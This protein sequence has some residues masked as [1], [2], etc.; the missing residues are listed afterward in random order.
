[1]HLCIEKLVLG[2]LQ[3]NVYILG[4]EDS[5]DAVII[6]PTFEPERQLEEISRRK[7]VLR[8]IWLTHGHYDHTTGALHISTAFD[9]SLPIAM[10]PESFTWAESQKN[11]IKFGL[12][13]D[14]V[15][16]LTTPLFQGKLLSLH[17]NGGEIVA[18]VREVPG[19]NP[20]SV[21]FYC[22]TINTAITGD[23]I[24]KGSIGRTDF[25]GGDYIL[26]IN[27]IRSQ[28][29]TLPEKTTLLP[30]HGPE[31]SVAY[32]RQFNTYLA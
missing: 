12:P 27:A 25:P 17:P 29:L 23:T 1:M 30:G 20:G 32:E 10:H 9:P 22:P 11:V 24:F 31:S 15:P 13:I 18:E 19:H 8:Q 26:L 21:I 7:W 3:N 28:I 4:D 14:P 5:R 16:T 2:P 6:D